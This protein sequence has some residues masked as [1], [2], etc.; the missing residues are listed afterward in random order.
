[1]EEKPEL[2]GVGATIEVNDEEELVT[3]TDPEIQKA[4]A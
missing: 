3:A 2:Q 1:M 4:E